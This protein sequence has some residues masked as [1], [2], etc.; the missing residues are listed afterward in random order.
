M[1]CPVSFACLPV[2]IA[3]SANQD[4]NQATRRALQVIHRDYT[5][6]L[7]SILERYASIDELDGDRSPVA[8]RPCFTDAYPDRREVY[9]PSRFPAI[10]RQTARADWTPE[11]VDI[12][13]ES[14]HLR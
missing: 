11:E 3:M 4:R 9:R 5:L 7:M 10:P 1:L 12:L 13:V 14:N 8:P 2:D 6:E